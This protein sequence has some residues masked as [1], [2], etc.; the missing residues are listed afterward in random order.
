MATANGTGSVNLAGVG[1]GATT[2]YN[3]YAAIAGTT[4]TNSNDG[5]GPPNSLQDGRYT[6]FNNIRQ[7]AQ[8]AG[9]TNGIWQNI[10]DHTGGSTTPGTGRMFIVNASTTPGE[11]YRRT[12]TGVVQGVPVNA[13]LWAMNLD[14]NIAANNNRTL[15]NITVNFV[16]SGVVVHT[17]STGNLPRE[18]LGSFSAWK[19][20]KN[21]NVFIPTSSAPITLV[22]VNNAP[23]GNG[24]DLA[25]DDIIIYQALCD[26]DND[27][28]PNYLD[29]DSDNDGCSDADEYYGL[30]TAD[31]N[32]DY[33]YGVGVP[34]VD[35]TGKVIAASYCQCCKCR[36]R[37]HY[38]KSAS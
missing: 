25:I 5:N 20:F 31:G 1:T 11:F 16:Q 27:G 4:P 21:E 24:N 7:T 22:L 34:A 8:W 29:L 19:F 10:G 6:V 17:F 15:P 9:G 13:S 37:E 3:Y 12:L 23:G 38:Y 33:V 35:A 28:I 30:T 14:T 26:T 2:T 36:K 32:D 18:A